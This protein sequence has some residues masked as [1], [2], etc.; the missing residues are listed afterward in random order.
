MS[1]HRYISASCALKAEIVDHLIDAAHALKLPDRNGK[2]ATV[3][4]V[5]SEGCATCEPMYRAREAVK[6]LAKERDEL[7]GDISLGLTMTVPPDA[8]HDLRDSASAMGVPPEWVLRAAV[9][10]GLANDD[11][12]VDEVE[13]EA[14]RWSMA[15]QGGLR[16]SMQ[17]RGRP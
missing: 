11:G 15:R 9:R 8:A 4:K 14:A 3:H 1:E 12:L 7:R 13:R 17:R 10:V 5:T 2:A 6:A 16:A